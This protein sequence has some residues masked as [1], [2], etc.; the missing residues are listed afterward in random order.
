[1]LFAGELT[2]SPKTL[3]AFA[4]FVSFCL[5][6]SSAYVFNDIFDAE[7]NAA[8]PIKRNRPKYSN[9][10]ALLR[11]Y[12]WVYREHRQIQGLIRRFASRAVQWK[13]GILGLAELFF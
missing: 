12:E 10:D 5:A 4:A 1:V 2:N 8:R 3:A 9:R 6:S 13:R 7:K 11:D